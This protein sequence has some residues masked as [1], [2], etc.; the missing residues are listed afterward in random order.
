M[1][2]RKEAIQGIELHDG[3]P[4]IEPIS[5]DADFKK[6]AADEKFMNELVTISIHTSPD[7]NQPNHVIVNCNGTN[8]LIIRGVPIRVK[9]KYVEILARMKETKYRQS[10]PN[11][12]A[13]DEIQMHSRSGQVYPFEVLEDPNQKGRAWLNHV[14]AEPA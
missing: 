10:T 1:A 12:A 5:K 7:E 3:D 4:E 13:P 8:Q 2:T 11:P 9:R 6:I 14:M